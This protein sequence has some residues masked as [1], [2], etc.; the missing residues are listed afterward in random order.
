MTYWY[1]KSKRPRKYDKGF[2]FDPS[3]VGNRGGKYNLWKGWPVKPVVGDVTIWRDYVKT[4]I[5]SG[6]EESFNFLEAL[7]AQM[8][9]EPH[10]KPGIAVVIR[11]DEGVGKSF[12]VEKLCALAK[13]YYFKT[14][15]PDNVFGKHNGH[16]EHVIL[17][18]LEEAVRAGSKKDESLL[19]D[20]IT[21]LVIRLTTNLYQSTPYQITCTYSLRVS[22]SK[23]IHQ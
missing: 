10:L 3:A 17:L 5:C 22:A 2:D 7:I 20:L 13:G 14:S 9:Q 12:F 1:F 18:H 11:G 23:T 4:I 19:K 21:G 8:F 16:L 15:N 6:D